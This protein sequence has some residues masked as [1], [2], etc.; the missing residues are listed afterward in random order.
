M[1]KRNE[2]KRKINIYIF[3]LIAFVISGLGC[4]VLIIMLCLFSPM[5]IPIEYFWQLV[6]F[7]G[8]LM[9]APIYFLHKR[10]KGIFIYSGELCCLVII[11]FSWIGFWLTTDSM[12]YLSGF[13]S[14]MLIASCAYKMGKKWIS[15]L[16]T[17]KGATF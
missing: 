16:M 6:I 15:T 11:F 12:Q 13:L 7:P 9:I 4:Y 17:F 14:I 2:E 5:P 8:G 10:T 3:P 1:V